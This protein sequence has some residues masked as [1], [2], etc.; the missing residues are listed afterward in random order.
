MGHSFYGNTIADVRDAENYHIKINNGELRSHVAI[1]TV[2]TQVYKVTWD[3][4]FFT[5]FRTYPV[6][7]VIWTL[8]AHFM[9]KID[10]SLVQIHTKSQDYSR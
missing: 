5:T 8:R 4:F 3:G 2:M 7:N 6:N 1:K 10:E 9:S